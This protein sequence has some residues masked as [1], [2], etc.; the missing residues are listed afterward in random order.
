MSVTAFKQSKLFFLK[1]NMF[2]L[3]EM[4]C[5]EKIFLIGPVTNVLLP[6][7]FCIHN[8]ECVQGNSFPF[9]E[10]ITNSFEVPIKCWCFETKFRLQHIDIFHSVSVSGRDAF[11]I[12]I[13]F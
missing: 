7:F 4:G 11:Q 8:G 3:K 12:G 6:N 2:F 10:C 9:C 1:C 5:I 13:P